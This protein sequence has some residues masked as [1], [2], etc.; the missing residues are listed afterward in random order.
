MFR[1]KSS[2]SDEDD[3]EKLTPEEEAKLLEKID[4]V[5]EEKRSALLEP[6]PTWRQWFFHE[7]L[8]W[9]I[10]VGF[11]IVDVWIVAGWIGNG[12][13]D[14]WTAAGAAGTTVVALYLEILIYRYFWRRPSDTDLRQGSR[15]RPSWT[16]LREV[17][18]WTPEAA[19]GAVRRAGASPDGGPD[20][21]E[22]L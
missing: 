4:R 7:C 1:S 19:E 12:A 20:S 10:G 16:A 21:K 17:G 22:F 2:A 15:F 11:L 8:K 6:G 5:Q 3:E 18:R 14:Q 13:L 9:W